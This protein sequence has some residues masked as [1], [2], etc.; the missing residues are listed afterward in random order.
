MLAAPPSAVEE[1]IKIGGLAAT[2]VARIRFILETVL[3][4]RPHD[5]PDG[6]AGRGSDET[7]EEQAESMGI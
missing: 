3:K 2:K 7:G 5:C 1:A 4:E 6:E